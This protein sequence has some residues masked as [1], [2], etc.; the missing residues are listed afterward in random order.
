MQGEE[1]LCHQGNAIP[2]SYTLGSSTQ[3]AMKAKEMISAHPKRMHAAETQVYT[4]DLA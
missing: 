1:R 4:Q 2:R 3:V